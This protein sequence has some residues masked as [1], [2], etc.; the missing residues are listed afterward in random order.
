LLSTT[1]F[2]PQSH[3]LQLS[4]PPNASRNMV[5]LDCLHEN[6]FSPRMMKFR[7]RMLLNAWTLAGALG[8]VTSCTPKATK[9]E[10][11]ATSNASLLTAMLP[12]AV[13]NASPVTNQLAG[14]DAIAP[15]EA[16]NHVGEV[17]TVRGKVFGV[18]VSQKGDVFINIGG[19]HPNAP[20]T[21]VCFQQAIPTE[22]LKVLEGK[23]ISVRGKIKDY[24]RQIE[25]VLETAEQIL[26]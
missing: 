15:E 8:L 7:F 2:T 16:K 10:P 9:S 25:I 4:R 13:T 3:G 6:G 5:R 21:A 26:K 12:A 24:N 23:T 1:R 11:A 18:Y 22:E 14:A 19:K 20:F 17:V